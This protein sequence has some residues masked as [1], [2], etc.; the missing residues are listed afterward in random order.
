[1]RPAA[2]TLATT[3]ML[4]AAVI[5]DSAYASDDYPTLSPFTAVKWVDDRPEVEVADAWYELIAINKLPCDDILTFCRKKWSRRWQKRFEQDLVE[6]LTRMQHKPGT[7]VALR[8]RK[9]GT[10]EVLDL[11]DVRMTT[12]NRQALWQARTDAQDRMERQQSAPGYWL[13]RLTGEQIAADIEQLRH[14]LDTQYAY[15]KLKGFDYTKHLVELR[16]RFAGGASRRDFAIALVKLVARFGDGHTRVRGSSRFFPSGYLPMALAESSE[17]IVALRPDRSALL[18]EEC[19]TVRRID[20]LGVEKWI[21]TAA[22]FVAD[23]SPQ[24]RRVHAIT[25]AHRA[26]LVRG[27]LEKHASDTIRVAVQNATGSLVKSLPFVVSAQ[28]PDLTP[29]SRQQRVTRLDHDIGYL[30]IPE[31]RGD[32]LFTLMLTRA[33]DTLRDTN[34]LIIDVRGNGGGTRTALRTLF[35]YFMRPDDSPR[36]ANVAR[37]RLR[38]GDKPDAPEGYLDNRSLYPL[39]SPHWTNDER[40]AIET[41]AAT[42]KPEWQVPS[43]EF[44]GWH[45]M[46]ISPEPARTGSCYQKPVVVLLDELCF[47]ATDIFLGAFKGWRH[48]TLMGRPSGG[49][50]GRSQPL[51]LSHSGLELR[52]SSMASF[53]PSGRLYDG[54]GIP[55]DMVIKSTIDD[56]LGKTDTTLEAAIKHLH[57]LQAA[58]P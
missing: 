6:V 10:Q 37:Y 9:P 38:P 32:A 24:F 27:E 56:I 23:G 18:D 47:S 39:A 31:M 20:G 4:A 51:E 46:V 26:Q 34:G 44:S 53:Q 16:E 12:A 58:R 14:A 11:T 49:G 42:F 40:A 1:M 13:Q 17:G 2:A 3:I 43:G 30:P 19:P 48:V 57:E 28:P 52:L 54:N 22:T 33:M 45:Y 41:F 5:P 35:P 29:R 36:V 15:A 50:S 7:T 55:P 8:V 25:R 21:D